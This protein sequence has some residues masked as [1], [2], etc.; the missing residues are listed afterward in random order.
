[1]VTKRTTKTRQ[2]DTKKRLLKAALDIFSKHGYDAATTRS[3]AKKAG[4]NESLIHRY[5][6][7]KHGL[8]LA[9]NQA[10]RE[11][12]L[13]EFLSYEEAGGLEEELVHLMKYRMN[14][15]SKKKKF[16]RLSLSRAI[17]DP[18]VRENIRN[19]ARVKPPALKD[20]FERFQKS[21]EIRADLDLD[22]VI[23]LVQILAFALSVLTDALESMETA[24][25]EK[26][27]VEA[28]QILA[29]GLK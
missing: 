11:N 25:A 1:M 24:D 15:T 12:L 2:L 23:S 4:V 9:L 19:Y 7:S 29:L 13:N 3:I 16:F 28:A 18:K 20:R 22:S 21:G 26:L 14:Q 10:F 6:D 17:L 27:I 5:F 8:F